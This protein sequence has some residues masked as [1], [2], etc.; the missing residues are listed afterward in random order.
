MLVLIIIIFKGERI[1]YPK[2]WK[3]QVQP[4]KQKEIFFSDGSLR[5]C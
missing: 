2:A 3:S 5:Q 1:E 4:K